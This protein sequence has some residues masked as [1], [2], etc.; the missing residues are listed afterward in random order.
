ML[1][2]L[3]IKNKFKVS[4]S[5][6]LKPVYFLSLALIEDDILLISEKETSSALILDN[7]SIYFLI[8][9]SLI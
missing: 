2:I 6:M 5:K 1:L 9:D 3:I 4:F 7:V 8:I